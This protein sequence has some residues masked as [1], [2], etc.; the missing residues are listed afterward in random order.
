MT[1]EDGNRLGRIR[2][3][4]IFDF[5]IALH[6][7]GVVW[8]I[9]GVA[10][11]T[12]VYLPM[13]NRLPDAE[14]MSHVEEIER[15]FAWQARIAVAVVG[16]TG[17]WMLARMGGLA[18]IANADAWWLDLMIFVWSVFA[19]MLFLVEP[20]GLLKKNRVAE[21]RLGFWLLHAVLLFL[22]LLAVVCGVL[23]ARGGFA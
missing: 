10:M 21:S 3:M 8:W 2:E 18:L 6:V 23:G 19:L 15:R 9:G 4:S 5:L 12:T 14:R 22:A 13:A 11:V 1:G 17:F 7:L 20:F 16:I